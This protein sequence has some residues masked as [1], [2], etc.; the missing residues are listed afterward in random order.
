PLPAA[1]RVNVYILGLNQLEEVEIDRI[2]KPELPLAAGDLS[3]SQGRAIVIA[4]AALPVVLAL[5]QGLI[6]TSAVVAAL[7]IGTAYSSP[8]LRLKRFPI[9]AS[10]SISVVRALVV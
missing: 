2:N 6:E 9:A 5:T 7:A 4:A 1:R 3:R 10:A 8:P